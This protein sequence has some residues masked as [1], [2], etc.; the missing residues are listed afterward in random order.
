VGPASGVAIRSYVAGSGCAWR[1]VKHGGF[2]HEVIT[3][4]IHGSLAD[5]DD[6]NVPMAA[7]LLITTT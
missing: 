5:A 7:G 6:I 2:S 3:E 1:I 4:H